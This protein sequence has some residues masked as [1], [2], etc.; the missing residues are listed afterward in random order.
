MAISKKA[1]ARKTSPERE[2]AGQQAVAR[3]AQRRK[4]EATA[5]STVARG[6]QL[7]KTGSRGMQAHVQARGQRNQARRDSR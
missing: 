4:A 6:G 7:G 3:K 1:S 2:A 5:A